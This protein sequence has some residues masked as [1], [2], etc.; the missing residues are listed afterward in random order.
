MEKGR[1]EGRQEASLIHAREMKAM[2]VD[3][4][5]IMKVTGIDIDSIE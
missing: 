1:E 2:N 3:R 4:E 5:I